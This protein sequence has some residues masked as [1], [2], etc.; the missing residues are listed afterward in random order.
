MIQAVGAGYCS[1]SLGLFELVAGY[2]LFQ[3]VLCFPQY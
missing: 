1:A 2:W 3:R